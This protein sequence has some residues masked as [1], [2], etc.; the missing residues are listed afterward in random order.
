[1]RNYHFTNIVKLLVLGCSL[2]VCSCS[3]VKYVPEG[4]QLLNKVRFK[5]DIPDIKTEQ[6]SPFLQQAP[7]SYMF[8]IMRVKLGVYNMSGRD[9][10]KWINRWLRKIGEAPVV[11][12]SLLT[13]RTKEELERELKNKGYYDAEV[14]VKKQEKKRK[15]KLTYVITGNEPYIISSYDVSLPDDSAMLILNRR[16]T[17]AMLKAGQLFDLALMDKERENVTLMLRN[18]GYYNFQKEL[19]G[20][21]AD[22]ANHKVALKMELQERYLKNDSLLEVIFCKKKVGNVYIYNITDAANMLTLSSDTVQL[23]TTYYQ[24]YC[25]IS[26]NRKK[27]IRASALA[28]KTFIR[29]HEM[30]RER[31]VTRTY[32]RLNNLPAVKYVNVSFNDVG[33][34]VLDCYIVVSPEKAHSFSVNIEGTNSDGNLGVGV[35]VTYQNRNI[36][37][38]SETLKIGVNG[39][40]E[41]MRKDGV[42]YHSAEIGGQLGIVFPSLL[43]PFSTKSFRQQSLGTTELSA[44]YNFQRRPE[45]VRN[46]AN[47]AFKYVWKRRNV[48]YTFDLIDFSLIYLPWMTDEFAEKYLNPSSSVR[49]S[50]EDH[51]ISRIGFGVSYTSPTRANSLRSYYSIRGGVQTAGNLLYG[52]SKLFKQEKNNG[53]YELFHVPYSQYVKGYFDFSYNQIFNP[54]VRLVWHT[55]LGIG[56]PYGNASVLPFEERFFAGGANGLRGW[57]VRSLGPGAYKNTTGYIDYMNQSGDIKFDLNVEARFK[58]FWKLEGAAFI[59]AGNIWTIK[60]YKEQPKGQ[61]QWSEF[62][63]QIGCSYGIGLRLNFDFFVIR[64]DMGLK[65]YDPCYETRSERWRTSFNWKD[66]VAFHFAVGYPF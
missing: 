3:S 22:S 44:S 5:S 16:D 1:M 50:Y 25:V 6:L 57:S 32:E 65:L 2:L 60:A 42:F 20:F 47:V 4:K 62:Y 13:Q 8:S 12:D 39:S 23:D 26:D 24:G 61:F 9:T 66:D 17:A 46:I 37:K 14:D 27:R 41:A 56:F 53:S 35:G 43:M 54:K 36:F 18:N 31:W 30:Y 15:V 7:N 11:Y 28:A 51:V 10:T 29:P 49:Y 64:V 19:L 63:K 40:Y 34:D 33:N 58:L 48:R 45:Y 38:G 52:L 21:K 59:D 55:A